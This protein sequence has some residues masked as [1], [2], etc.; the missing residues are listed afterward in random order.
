MRPLLIL[1]NIYYLLFLMTPQIVSK[2]DPLLISLKGFILT[3]D[4]RSYCTPPR[5]TSSVLLPGGL[6]T[7]E[8]EA[9]ELHQNVPIT[10]RLQGLLYVS[11][12]GHYATRNKGFFHHQEALRTL[13]WRGGL[14]K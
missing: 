9:M 11:L 14:R 12:Y 8:L 5:R 2:M 4:T 7:T 1:V 10:K 13:V 3:E 6:T